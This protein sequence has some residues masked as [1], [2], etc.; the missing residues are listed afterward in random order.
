MTKKQI[1][2]RLMPEAIKAK[3]MALCDKIEAEA[4]DGTQQGKTLQN[5]IK[6]GITKVDAGE[7]DVYL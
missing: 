4:A 5:R 1:I 6:L 7:R 3:G 2:K